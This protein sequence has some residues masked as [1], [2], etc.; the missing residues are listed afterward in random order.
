MVFPLALDDQEWY[1][2]IITFPS[3][4]GIYTLFVILNFVIT[5][6]VIIKYALG[7]IRRAAVN[8]WNFGSLNMETLIALGSVSA[9]LLFVFFI[10]RYTVSYANG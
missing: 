7:F 3:A 9:F 4:F 5:L 2:K 6:F 10:I 8:Y 1:D